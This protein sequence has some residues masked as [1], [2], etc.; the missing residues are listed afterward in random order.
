MN[1]RED[2]SV[3]ILQTHETF[4]CSYNNNHLFQLLRAS[5]VPGP[6]I[7]VLCH[8]S[9]QPPAGRTGGRGASQL[10]GVRGGIQFTFPLAQSLPLLCHSFQPDMEYHLLTPRCFSFSLFH[11]LCFSFPAFP[12]QLDITWLHFPSLHLISSGFLWSLDGRYKTYRSE[13]WEPLM[14]TCSFL[15]PDPEL[16]LTWKHSTDSSVCKSPSLFSIWLKAERKKN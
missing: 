8:Q 12:Y 7:D 2:A 16:L 3:T 4:I 9:P 6:A 14:T 15:F 11:M 13:L 10:R 1:S 5:S